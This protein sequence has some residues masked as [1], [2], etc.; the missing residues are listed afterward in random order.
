MKKA[1][2]ILLGLYSTVVLANNDQGGHKTNME[3]RDIKSAQELTMETLDKT[4]I[5]AVIDIY[6]EGL[7]LGRVDLLKKTFYKDAIMYGFSTENKI[8]EGSVQHLYDI[9]EKNGALSNVTSTNSIQHRTSNTASVLAELKNTAPN[10]NS[11]D[12]L[13]LMKINGEWKIISKVYHLSHAK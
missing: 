3:T 4:E 11:T 1:Y 13:S 6:I 8:T 9:I 7:R 10:Q 2:L 12:Y 5:L